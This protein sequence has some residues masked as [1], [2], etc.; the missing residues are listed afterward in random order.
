MIEDIVQVKRSKKARRV[1][2]RLDPVERIINLVVPEH[3]PLK[4]AYNF[5][6]QHENWVHKTLEKLPDTI[7]YT[8][9]TILPVF[10]DQVRLDITTDSALKRTTLKQ[11]DDV[12]KIKT[13]QEDP[14]SRITTHLKK[15]A[16]AGLSDIA[17]EKA[18]MIGKEIK[19]VKIRDTKSRWGSCSQ[20]GNMSFSWRLMFA[21][22]NSIDYV[23]AHEVA[24]LIHMNHSRK[25]WKLC[26]ELSFDYENGKRW[27]KQNGN[28]LMRYGHKK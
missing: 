4:T 8:H 24:H 7:S 27:M 9:G 10:G 18:D 25:F 14:S 1:A 26:K 6:R 20:D 17:S 15:I 21:P 5:A 22:Y 2:L 13:Y 3:M 16:R 19:S 11:Y 12:L 23:V 28:S